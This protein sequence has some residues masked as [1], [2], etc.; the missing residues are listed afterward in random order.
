M[1]LRHR[2]AAAALLSLA[3]CF[4]SYGKWTYPSGRY[5]QTTSPRP[6]PVFVLVEPL[7]DHRGAENLSYMAWSYVP[8]MPYGW[9]NFD[10]PEAV[11]HSEDTTDYHADPCID[12]PRSIVVELQRQRLVERVE[13][14]PDFRSGFGE[15]HRLRGVL[16]A[17]RLDETRWT[18]GLSIY[19]PAAWALGLPM[20]ESWNEFC[21]DLELT[22]V[23]SGRVVW[24]ESVF[25]ADCWLEGYYYGP[26]WYRFSWMWERRLRERLGELA[27]VLGAVAA[28]LPPELVDD[29]RNSP[30][31]VMPGELV[32]E[33]ADEGAAARR[34]SR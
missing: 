2:C 5:P 18:Y 21:V 6:A 16:R 30:A 15:T 29:L 26:E 34:S 14:T 32:D 9:K 4:T 10:R 13:F 27:K 12:L 25:D 1:A 24:S 28:P 8:L 11:V 23:A 31:P 7:I 22:E 20:G 17:F 33:A 19:A 3:G